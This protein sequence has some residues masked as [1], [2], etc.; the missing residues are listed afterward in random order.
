MKNTEVSNV[1][2]LQEEAKSAQNLISKDQMDYY[3]RVFDH[4]DHFLSN[5]LLTLANRM[6][7][8]RENMFDQQMPQALMM[9]NPDVPRVFTGYE[10]EVGKY[11]KSY[12]QADRNWKILGKISRYPNMPNL[13]YMLIVRDRNGNLDIIHRTEAEQLTES[14]GYLNQNEEIDSKNAGD[15]INK[16]EILYRATSFDSDMNYCY[17]KNVTFASISHPEIAEDEVI[18]SDE[19]MESLQYTTLTNIAMNLNTNELLL[20]I[21]GNSTVYKTFPDIGEKIELGVLCA[22]RRISNKSMVYNLRD[23]T[24]RNIHR[25][26]DDVYYSE[27]VVVG[28]DVF[29][30][31]LPEDMPNDPVNAQLRYYY[32]V[33]MEYYK[34]LT[35]FL[36]GLLK[37]TAPH[38]VSKQLLH[39]YHRAQDLLSHKPIVN[40]NAKFENMSVIFTVLCINK[41]K[42]GYKVTGRFGEK[43]VIGHHHPRSQMPR[44]EF[45]EVADMVTSPGGIFGR[46]NLGQWSEQE[47][48]FLADNIVRDL[49]MANIPYPVGMPK[50]FEFLTDVYKP[51]AD[52]MISF[53]NGLSETERSQFYAS[54]IAH[55]LKLHQPPF[56]GNSGFTELR[57]LYEKYPYPRYK[58]TIN[59]ETCNRRVI[60]G[61][62]YI[63]L[64]KQTPKSKYSVRS[65]GMQN[66]IGHPS[67]SIRFKNHNLP[68]SD[69]PIRIGNMELFNLL[70]MND[71]QAVADFLSTYANSLGNREAFVTTIL[72]APDPRVINFTP[73]EQSG[74]N[75]KMMNAYLKVCGVKLVDD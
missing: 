26:E 9:I 60:F 4:S 62:K 67:K 12:Y 5:S 25:D 38:K 54:I 40:G 59:G 68:Y 36:G 18:L 75:R 20:N 50:I 56:W 22:K 8:P 44:N 58:V 47:L 27:G 70:I 23:T 14:Y 2:L 35:S 37:Q 1:R 24:L 15:R 6:S 74:I 34:K 72:T 64:L 66:A 46:L 17:G 21:Y 28:V 10:Y 19:F 32:D 42:K 13:D 30:N 61:T 65:L 11:S 69:T 49:K 53:Y 51:Y 7:S 73:P 31:K 57:K 55:G 43:G 3:D 16:G 63:M 48:T 52:K 45:G 33:E 41:A 29:S 71:S 39:V